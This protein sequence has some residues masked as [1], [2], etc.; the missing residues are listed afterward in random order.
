MNVILSLYLKNYFGVLGLALAFSLSAISQMA[1]LL[2]TLRFRLKSLHE[3]KI[4]IS[5]YKI[6]VAGVFMAIIIQITKTPLANLVDMTKFW[7]IF[8]QGAVAGLI[9]LLVY[10]SICW[11]LRLE[12]MQDFLSSAKR[13]WLK[14]QN[15]PREVE[16]NK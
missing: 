12:E 9:G 16:E 7:G 14:L 2:I 4:L 6:S 8:T 11:L 3:S 5:L 1:L 10:S 15:V 13:R